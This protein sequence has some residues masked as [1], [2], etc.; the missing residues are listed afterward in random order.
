MKI[1]YLFH[2]HSRTWK[3]C[4]QSFFDNVYSIAPGDIYIHTW[5]RVNSKYGSHWNNNYNI[6]PEEQEKISS[7]TLD[8][9]KIKKTY[10]PKHMFVETDR[11][12]EFPLHQCP[13]LANTN[14]TL[15]HM[16]VYNMVRA[17]NYVFKLAESCGD[18]DR[19]FSCRFDLF[20]KNKLDIKEL[21]YEEYMMVPNDP[22][23]GRAYPSTEMIYDIYAFG[24]KHA[25]GTRAD[26]YNHI[27]EYWYSK[28]DLNSYFIEHAATKYYNDNG[29][30]VKPSSLTFDIKRLF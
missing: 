2:G 23:N 16:G 7:K 5:D 14:A 11:G 3:D 13:Q 22:L 18:Y 25:I 28:D 8:L 6:L 1:A 30:K 27:W 29:L 9:A 26:L 20:F 12:V 19:Y 15:A 10:K 4:Y 24:T 17:Q 21:Y